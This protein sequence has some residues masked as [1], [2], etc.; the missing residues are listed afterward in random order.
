MIWWVTL[1]KTNLL[2]CSPEALVDSAL[3]ERVQAAKYIWEIEANSVHHAHTKVLLA[4][5]ERA[6]YTTPTPRLAARIEAMLATRTQPAPQP[7]RPLPKLV[8]PQK[9]PTHLDA[10][11]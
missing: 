6:Q 9:A 10:S 7:A 4:L 5:L 3:L 1:S 11:D 2:Q 8:V